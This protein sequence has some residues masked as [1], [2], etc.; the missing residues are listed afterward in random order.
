[1]SDE[2]EQVIG[3]FHKRRF[4]FIEPDGAV[5]FYCTE[6]EW[7]IPDYEKLRYE[8]ENPCYLDIEEYEEYY[9]G[10]TLSGDGME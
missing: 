4:C 8:I 1:M 6:E 3:S 2:G 9:N 7:S 5:S 10:S